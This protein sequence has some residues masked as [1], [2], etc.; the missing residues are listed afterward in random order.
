M[1]RVKEAYLIQVHYAQAQG[2]EVGPAPYHVSPMV[3]EM[4]IPRHA[5]SP[6]ENGTHDIRTSRYCPGHSFS[7]LSVVAWLIS[8]EAHVFTLLKYSYGH[9]ALLT[10]YNSPP[11]IS[12][13]DT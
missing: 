8:F 13:L 2:I 4:H 1:A 12:C 5:E 6:R 10:S 9:V 11:P 7:D 3:G